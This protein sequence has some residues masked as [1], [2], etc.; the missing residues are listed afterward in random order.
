MSTWAAGL[1]IREEVGSAVTALPITN[2]GFGDI[3]HEGHAG[4]KDADEGGSDPSR[5]SFKG[6]EQAMAKPLPGMYGSVTIRIF[7]L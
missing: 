3:D 6:G 1:P 5:T 2:R 4:R 7:D